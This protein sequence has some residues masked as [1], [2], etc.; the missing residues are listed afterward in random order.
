MGLAREVY[1]LFN[2]PL[3]QKDE[4]SLTIKKYR[5]CVYFSFQN[6]HILWHYSGKFYIGGWEKGKDEGGKSGRGFEMVPDN[7][8][9][10]GEFVSGKREGYGVLNSLKGDN[11]V[12]QWYQGLRHGKGR[13]EEHSGVVYDGHW[14]NGK[15]DGFGRLTFG[16]VEEYEGSFEDGLKHG[17]GR[18]IYKNRDSY[19]GEYFM[20]RFSG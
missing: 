2:L 8:I 3:R 19:K 15:K 13:L 9:Y 18:E 6:K 10:E 1:S 16:G 20:G 5:N 14:K 4:P 12:G 7:Y 17:F 11:Y